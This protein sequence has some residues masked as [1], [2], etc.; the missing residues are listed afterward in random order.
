MGHRA[1]V[2]ILPLRLRRHRRLVG[3]GMSASNR[4]SE[5]FDHVYAWGNNEFR[6]RFKGLRCRIV[7]TGTRMR[8]VEVEFEDG[9]RFI[10][11]ARAV[12]KA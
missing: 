9:T 10:T 12:R 3:V 8:S 2:G 6:A 7:A 4:G 5:R 11:S 1:R